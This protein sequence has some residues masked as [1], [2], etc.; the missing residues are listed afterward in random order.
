MFPAF[1]FD[2]NLQEIP[3]SN[4]DFNAYI[5]EAESRLEKMEAKERQQALAGC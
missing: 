2:E 5:G 1:S 3:N 4:E